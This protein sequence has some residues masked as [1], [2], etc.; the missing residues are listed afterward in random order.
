MPLNLKFII[1]GEEEVGSH[2]LEQ[3]IAE[4]ADRLAC[5]CVV[6]S[7][8]GQFAAAGVPAITYGLRGIAYYELNVHGPGAICTPARLAARSRIRPTLWPKYLPG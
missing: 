6:I 2:G 1:E 8:G 4:H 3:Y 5:D 7:D